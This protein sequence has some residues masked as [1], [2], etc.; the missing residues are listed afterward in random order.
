MPYE[1]L[2][3]KKHAKK[4]IHLGICGSVAAYKSLELMR[5]FLKSNIHVSAT[6]TPSAEKFIQ[7][8][9]FE[10]LGAN[11]VYRQMFQGEFPFEHL[12]PSQIADA[13]VIAPASATTIARLA[14]G[15]GDEMLACQALAFDGPILLA[16]AM[17][18][19]MWGNAAT[20]ANIETLLNRGFFLTEP[21]NGVVACKDEGQ[22][23]LARLEKIYYDS[24]ALLTEQDLYAKKILI[25]LG[26]TAEKWDAVRVWTNNSTGSMGTALAITAWLRGADVYV[27]AG[28]NS[29]YIPQDSRIQCHSVTSADEMYEK[30]HEL[31][32][33]MD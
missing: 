14:H 19:K 11:K 7:P 5:A 27:V 6:L 20:N 33:A 16:P 1:L 17:N 18:P 31:W 9:C 8:L 2:H 3:Y 29:Q 13:M 32:D 30:C 24:L 15:L 12:E 10:A 22:G 26:P 28:P 4:H 23:R 25:T 21:E